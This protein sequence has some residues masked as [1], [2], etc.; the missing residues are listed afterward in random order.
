MAIKMNI[1]SKKERYVLLDAVR[2]LCL[3]SMI[4]YHGTYDLVYLYGVS[5]PWYQGMPGYIWQQS[6]CWTFIILSGMCWSLGRHPIKR[7]VIIFACG[8]VITLITAVAMPAQIVQFGILTFM[9][10]AMLL[11]VIIDWLVK[12][13]P[14]AI[15]LLV[16]ILLFVL[17]RNVNRGELGFEQ[18]TLYRLPKVERD[19]YLLELL[20]FP[21]DSFYS[22]DYFS[23]FPWFFLYLTGYFLWKLLQQTK[24]LQEGAWGKK[25][26]T[27]QIPG[28]MTIGRWTLPIYMLHQPALLLILSLIEY[29]TG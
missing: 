23:L 5:L 29:Q 19:S 14:A 16:S 28:I 1:Q 12:G 20:G 6:I 10:L 11:T 27:L 9:G 7:G 13:W 4:L 21:T 26:L 24:Q 3:I 22:S 15:G 18:L 8:Q 25:L 2:G 17:S